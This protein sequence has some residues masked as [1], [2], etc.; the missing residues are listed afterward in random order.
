MQDWHAMDID[1]CGSCQLEDQL[2]K[3]AA[4][5]LLWF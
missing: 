2:G 5:F 4:F 3:F 1:L